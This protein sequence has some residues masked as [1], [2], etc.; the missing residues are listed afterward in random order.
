MSSV[1]LSGNREG[2]F[3]VRLSFILACAAFL[4]AILL[5]GLIAR[6][7]VLQRAMLVLAITAIGWAWTLLISDAEPNGRWRV[8]LSFTTAAY[9]TASIPAFFI[10]LSVGLLRY[11][12]ASMCARPWVHWGYAL[13]CLGVLGS[14]SGRGRTR[15]ALLLGSVALWSLR[16]SG[17][18]IL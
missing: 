10:E 9:L 3:H 4:I 5:P 2:P 8:W 12:A 6:K 14:F 17:A 11:P 16:A 18:W 13:T 15:V 1:D 7:P